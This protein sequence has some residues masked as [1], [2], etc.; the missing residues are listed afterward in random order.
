MKIITLLFFL[1]ASPA[2]ATGVFLP[3][4]VEKDPST[5]ASITIDYVHTENH[6]GSLFEYSTYDTV[7]NVAENV[8]ILLTTPNSL[9]WTHM[10]F[11]VACG[12]HCTFHIYESST[13]TAG[14]AFTAYSMNRNSANTPTLALNA[15]AGGGVDGTA[16]YQENLGVSAAGAVRY[17]GGGS[18]RSDSEFILK[19][20]T[21]Y[22]IRVTSQIDL[23]AVS[24]TLSWYEHTDKN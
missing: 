2:L 15:N 10:V 16:I 8:D 5:N 7:V 1:L 17:I 13:H 9:K 24:L 4:T 6:S 21:K 3:S 20:N 22:L 19:Q 11:M 18:A 14:A 12:M 23:N